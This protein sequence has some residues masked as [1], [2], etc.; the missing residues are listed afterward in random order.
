[1]K[2]PAIYIM[3]NKP[4]GTLYT[5]VTSNLAQRVYQHKKSLFKGF[6]SRYGCKILVYYEIFDEMIYA[7]IREK[8]LKG[9]SRMQKLR[10]IESFNPYWRDLSESIF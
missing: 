5:G 6:T 4:V 3:T 10:L 9:G 8:Q 1:M 7:I 2:Q